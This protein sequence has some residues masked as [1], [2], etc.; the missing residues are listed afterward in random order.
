MTAPNGF[1]SAVYRSVPPAHH[2]FS[3]DEEP[4]AWDADGWEGIE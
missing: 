3:T 4:L 2:E 1:D